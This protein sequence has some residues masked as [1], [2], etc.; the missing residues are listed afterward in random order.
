MA[1]KLVSICYAVIILM[2]CSN[3]QYEMYKSPCANLE[4]PQKDFKA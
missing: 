3:K 2:G 1:L 4:N